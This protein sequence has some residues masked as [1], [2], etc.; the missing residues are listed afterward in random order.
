LNAA[1]LLHTSP[2]DPATLWHQRVNGP[3]APAQTPLG[4]GC[5]TFTFSPAVMEAMLTVP[6]TLAAVGEFDAAAARNP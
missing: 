4:A 1:C 5:D 6:A 2:R 3:R